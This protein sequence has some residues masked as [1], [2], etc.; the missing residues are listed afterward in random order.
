MFKSAILAAVIA[1]ACTGFVVPALA[2]DDD[3][4]PRMKFFLWNGGY[5]QETRPQHMKDP[6]QS[7]EKNMDRPVEGKRK[8]PNDGQK[9][10]VSP[11]RY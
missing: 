11:N 2:G 8:T 6:K 4:D 1:V 5:D 7:G 3:E 9:P 10:S